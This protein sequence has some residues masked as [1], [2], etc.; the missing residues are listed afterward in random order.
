MTDARAAALR[1]PR[2][3][4]RRPAGGR[5]RSAA[6]ARLGAAR[7]RHAHAGGGRRRA[8]HDRRRPPRMAGDRRRARDA[9]SRRRRAAADAAIALGPSLGQCCGGALDAALHA[10]GRRRP[11]R[12]GRRQRRGSRCSSTAPAMSAARSPR[13]W[14]AS[15]VPR[16]VDRRT[17][18]RV[19][20]SA[21]AAAHR[22]ARVEPVE[23]EVDAAP[24][25]AFYLVL[26]HSHDLDLAITPA[27]LRRGDFGFFGLIGSKT[28][29]A[30]FEHRLRERGV[31]DETL[32]AHGLPDR[33]ARHRRQGARGDRGR[34]GGAAAAA[35][36]RLSRPQVAGVA[37]MMRQRKQ[38]ARY[39]DDMTPPIP[40][41]PHRWKFIRAGGV[42]QVV[43]RSGADIVNLEHL[44]QKLWV[45]LAC[46]TRRRRDRR[47]HAGPDRHRQRRPHPAARADRRQPLDSRPLRRPR[48]AD[49]AAATRVPLAAISH[50]HRRRPPARRRGRATLLAL[51]GR[52]TPTR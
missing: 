44:D 41:T 27:I 2:W 24:P 49:R 17:R 7:G 10:A 51:V 34:G 18:Q 9:G 4:R 23:A 13:C 36:R 45:A 40:T 42:D 28:K 48:P 37:G 50:R 31:A 35:T 39:T 20:G 14:P 47:T 30:R 38:D 21:V 43:I 25:G 15:A 46:P 19:P 29:R 22:A 3:L 33:R 11:G 16:A 8:R 32:R 5:R 6:H 52:P 1:A 26:T 12:S